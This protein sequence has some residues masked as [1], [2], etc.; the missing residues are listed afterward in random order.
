MDILVC[1]L[2]KRLQ[3]KKLIDLL[4]SRSTVIVAFPTTPTK[5]GWL[6]AQ[7]ANDGSI[8]NVNI[9]LTKCLSLKGSNGSAKTVKMFR[10]YVH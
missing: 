6:N 1:S 4:P 7:S 3:A 8:K 10:H 5:I 9:F 2:L